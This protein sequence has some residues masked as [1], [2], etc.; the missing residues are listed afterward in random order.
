[1][2]NLALDTATPW[3]RF[4]LAD[5]DRL[6]AYRPL[7]IQGSYADALLPV[8]TDLL[9][10]TGHGLA[11]LA[12][13]GVTRG[14]GSFTG[15]RIGVATAKA[16]AYALSCELVA[17]TTLEAMAAALL[18]RHPAAELAVPV[19]DARRGEIFT[20]VYAREGA[21]VRTLVPGAA[22]DPDTWW[23]KIVAAVPH[24]ESPVYGGEGASLL[25]GQ[26]PTLRPQ[27]RAVGEPRLRVWTSS[28]PRTAEALALAMGRGPS[29]LPRIHPFSLTPRY[30]RV[31]DAEIKRRI[32]LTPLA[33]RDGI[34]AH[35][36][37][38]TS[39]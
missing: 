32:D 12:G 33:P 8:I 13:M 15:V 1:M 17:V 39:S 4:A 14:P 11:D 26:G 22:A 5:G 31:S 37:D 30:L 23:E 27:L 20:G 29:V 19:L 28:H 36:G 25:L 7:N 21:W 10:E 3:G 35:D 16:L 9:A 38:R 24:A 6:L 34:P 18:H 2:L